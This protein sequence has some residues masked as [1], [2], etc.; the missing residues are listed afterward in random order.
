MDD[1]MTTPNGDD[2]QD[3]PTT[4]PALEENPENGKQQA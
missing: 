3:A 2:M 1:N 4:P